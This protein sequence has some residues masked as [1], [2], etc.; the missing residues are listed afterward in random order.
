MIFAILFILLLA[1]F[2]TDAVAEMA[3]LVVLGLIFLWFLSLIG[4]V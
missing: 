2:G 1:V 3:K 4:A